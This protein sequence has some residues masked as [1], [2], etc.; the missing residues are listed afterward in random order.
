MQK[1]LNWC[2]MKYNDENLARPIYLAT[3]GQ[4]PNFCFIGSK[5]HIYLRNVT[6][7]IENDTRPA[8]MEPYTMF[9][10]TLVN[11]FLFPSSLI[12]SERSASQSSQESSSDQ[13]PS[14]SY[15]KLRIFAKCIAGFGKIHCGFLENKLWIFGKYIVDFWKM[16]WD[17]Y[18]IHCGFLQNTLWIQFQ[19]E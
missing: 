3:S 17:F 12:S 1:F 9:F 16:H 8:P 18:K 6:N 11:I 7:Q 13:C 19:E 10:L 2:S 4:G 5:I 14:S 15:N